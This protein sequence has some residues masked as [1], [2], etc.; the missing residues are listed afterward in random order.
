LSEAYKVSK[1]IS[2]TLHTNIDLQVLELLKSWHLS[3]GWD[4]YGI[5]RE[6]ESNITVQIIYVLSLSY[7]FRSVVGN[8]S[9]FMV[10]GCFM[11]SH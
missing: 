3:G 4:V 9:N 5:V 7:C 1:P 6:M 2:W 11:S 8:S 10:N